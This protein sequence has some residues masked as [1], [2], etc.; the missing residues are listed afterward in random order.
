MKFEVQLDSRRAPAPHTTPRRPS[1]TAAV[2]GEARL[3]YCLNRARADGVPNILG[4][5]ALDLGSA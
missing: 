2:F 5:Q 1:A 4:R 3:G